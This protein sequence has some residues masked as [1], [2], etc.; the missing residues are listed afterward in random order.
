MGPRTAFT[1]IHAYDRTCKLT[2]E[3]P[4]GYEIGGNMVVMPFRLHSRG[5][6][7][8][9]RIDERLNNPDGQQL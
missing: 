9:R 7:V 4:I 8:G 3:H 2:T 1:V 6:P 5:P